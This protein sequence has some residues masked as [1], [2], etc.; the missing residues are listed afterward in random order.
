[1]NR[2]LGWEGAAAQK[3]RARRKHGVE[4]LGEGFRFRKQRVRPPRMED[5]PRSILADDIRPLEGL[6]ERIRADLCLALGRGERKRRPLIEQAFA[7]T[8]AL[9]KGLSKL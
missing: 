2:H 3:S 4:Y 6:V 1:M 8:L 5:R 7:H 9:G